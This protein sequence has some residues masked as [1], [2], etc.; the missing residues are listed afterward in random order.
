MSQHRRTPAS[1]PRPRPKQNAAPGSSLAAS[2]LT[3]AVFGISFALLVKSK[4]RRLFPLPKPPGVA[5]VQGRGPS[6][7]RGWGAA[8]PTAMP[9]RG[10]GDILWRV[11]DEITSDRVLIVA[12]GVTFYAILSLFPLIT[13]FVSV[14]GIFA[15]RAAVAAHVA[16]LEDVVPDEVLTLITEQLE[17]LLAV[18][19]GTLTLTSLMS[20]AIAFWAANGGIKGLIEAMNVAYDQVE[21]RSFFKL[22]LTAFSM[23]IGAMVIVA[24]LIT[25]S[26]VLPA[27][28]ENFPG[29]P[30]RDAALTWGRWPV[31][32]LILMLVLAALY[33]F[34]PDRRAAKWR[35]VTAGA[36]FAAAGV[37]IVSAGFA[38]YTAR[39]A[40]YGETYGSLGTV[41]A[42]MMW[43]WLASIVVIIGAEINAE[44][45]HQTARDTTI[46]PDRPMGQRRAA[47]ADKVAPAKSKDDQDASARR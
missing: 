38:F 43:F 24:A 4:E 35:W 1:R 46:G 27:I 13:A 12:A 34:G 17:R 8:T 16:T 36:V 26:A 2:V 39:F 3:A 30:A 21:S 41:V 44:T 10:W 19:A 28:V 6:D 29:G 18:E 45:E 23:T 5:D 15:D 37:I 7:G 11:K 32:A 14:Y 31:M 40:A 25:L 33:R 20:L 42:V 22:N 47:M 9:G